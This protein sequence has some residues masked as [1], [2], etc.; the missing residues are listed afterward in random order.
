[1][2]RVL[3]ESPYRGD[4]Y[5]QTP[6]HVAYLTACIRDSLDRGEAPFASHALYPGA[7]DDRD[8][9]ERKAGIEAGLCI[10]RD[11]D[12]TAVYADHG[13]SSGVIAGV[14]RAWAEGRPVEVRYLWTRDLPAGTW[15]R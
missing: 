11:F 14:E 9:A 15:S 10:G 8:P 13:L 6:A 7:Y 3:I 1:M 5:A 4:N 2:N 12:L